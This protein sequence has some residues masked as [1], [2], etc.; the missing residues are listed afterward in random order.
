MDGH[1][2]AVDFTA[3]QVYMDIRVQQREHERKRI[4]NHFD[5]FMLDQGGETENSAATVQE[6][7]ISVVNFFSRDPGDILLFRLPE[8]S[9]DPMIRSFLRGR[10][11]NN[12]F[13]R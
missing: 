7:R 8:W 9:R 11:R 12:R 6:N 10:N 13:R 1:T 5:L 3:D 4:R 2:L